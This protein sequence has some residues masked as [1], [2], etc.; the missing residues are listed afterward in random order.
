VLPRKK[1]ILAIFSSSVLICE[2]YPVF[3]PSQHLCVF[4][5]S[6]RYLWGEWS[7]FCAHRGTRHRGLSHPQSLHGQLI[8][9]I[10][11]II[12]IAL[13]VQSSPWRSMNTIEEV[14]TP[15]RCDSLSRPTGR[16]V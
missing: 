16:H 9:T 7:F 8:H 2:S 11:T 10:D 1:S 3:S 14:C 6:A 5:A 4:C 12:V 13:A 15:E